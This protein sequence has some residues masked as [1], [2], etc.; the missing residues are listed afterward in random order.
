MPTDP[1]VFISIVGA[2]L[3]LL[4]FRGACR[5]RGTSEDVQAMRQLLTH[6]QQRLAAEDKLVE[7]VRQRFEEIADRLTDVQAS[8]EELERK[9]REPLPRRASDPA[10]PPAEHGD[11]CQP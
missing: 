8:M 1:W 2:L 9:S 7:G 11:V 6:A 3:S 4:R 10:T 5:A